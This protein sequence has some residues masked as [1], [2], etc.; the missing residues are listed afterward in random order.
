MDEQ[1]QEIKKI[2]DVYL[3]CLGTNFGLIMASILLFIC[4]SFQL[5]KY[6]HLIIGIF[7]VLFSQTFVLLINIKKQNKK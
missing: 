2:K 3:E 6:Y 5:I 7:G 1:Y 4:F